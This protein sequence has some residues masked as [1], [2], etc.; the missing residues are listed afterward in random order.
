M[1]DILSKLN[2][3]NK[4]IEEVFMN[5]ID[6]INNIPLAELNGGLGPFH[7]RTEWGAE[8]WEEG[9]WI[10]LNLVELHIPV[11]SL[12]PAPCSDV[13]A[14]DASV[15]R[16]AES[17][18]GLVIGLRAAIVFRTRE[19]VSLKVIGPVLRL[20]KPASPLS[21]GHEVREELRYFERLVQLWVITNI[22]AG[23]YLFDGTL[24]A[25][26]DR[27]NSLL[28]AVLEVAEYTSRAILGF[29]KESLLVRGGAEME[30]WDRDISPPYVRDL[31]GPI[32]SVWSGIKPLGSVFLVKLAPS[33]YPFR[34]DAYPAERGIDAL[35]S[36]LSSDALI[37]GYP[38]TLILAHT[39]ATFS[40]MDVVAMRSTLLGQT[41]TAISSIFNQRLMVLTPFE[42]RGHEDPT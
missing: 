21:I 14:V 36:L 5:Y 19:G 41:S 40:W 32:K 39:H 31:T 37:H 35:S 28:E 18:Q 2:T 20:V 7:Q 3:M 13:V 42:T 38:E 22:R 15:V 8:L 12:G 25:G 1:D 24:V 34:V 33:L 10:P 4:P 11:V 23:I 17:R 6:E 29:S 26:Y 27:S 16:V 9:D 30:L